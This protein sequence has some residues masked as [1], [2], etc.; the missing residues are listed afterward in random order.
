MNNIQK[1]FDLANKKYKDITSYNS[2]AY[3]FFIKNNK[4]KQVYAYDGCRGFIYDCLNSMISI[5]APIRYF[6]YILYKTGLIKYILNI[7]QPL[8]SAKHFYIYYNGIRGFYNQNHKITEK[9]IELMTELLDILNY[10]TAEVIKHGHKVLIKLDIAILKNLYAT[11]VLFLLIKYPEHINGKTKS[12][13]SFIEKIYGKPAAAN[14]IA[15]LKGWNKIFPKKIEWW[16]FYGYKNYLHN[17]GLGEL[18]RRKTCFKRINKRVA[19][20]QKT[21]NTI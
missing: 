2:K 11:S 17:E 12:F 20:L 13:Y 16:T 5:A 18:T 4:I 9:S 7:S 19:V 1:I 6:N 21:Q 10:P 14:H 8:A 15:V 3:I